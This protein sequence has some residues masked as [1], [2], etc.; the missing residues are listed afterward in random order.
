M[1]YTPTNW[2]TGDVITA[3]KLNK[4]EHGIETNSTAIYTV[5]IKLQEGAPVILEGVLSDALEAYDAG[6]LVIVSFDLGNLK[7][8]YYAVNNAEGALHFAHPYVER[9][10]LALEGI[11]WS[12]EGLA[13]WPTTP[14]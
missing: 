5:F 7:N 10:K 2:K 1:A 14:A 6:K 4:A 9:G 13:M 12:S 11:R 3:E 8:T